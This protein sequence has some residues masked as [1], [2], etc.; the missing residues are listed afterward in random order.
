MVLL[1]TGAAAAADPP[2][3][4]D[5]MP[6][7][8]RAV[9]AIM[10][11]LDS[12]AILFEQDADRRSEPA[13]LTKVMTLYLIYEALAKGELTLESALPVSKKAWQMEGSRTFV[14]VGAEVQVEQLIRGIAVQSGND[15]CVVVAEHLGGSEAGF[16]D[17]MN[18]KAQE[19]G[20]N[21]THFMNA[22]GLP[23]DEHYTT[24]RDLFTL[25]RAITLHF[26]Q[27][28]HFVR[29]KEYTFNGILQHNRNR[30]LWRDS[31]ITGLKTGHTTSAGYCLIATSEKDGQRL[32]SVM[33]GAASVPI[34]S[35]DSLQMLRYGN[36]IFESV[37]LYDK[38]APVR[39]LRVWKGDVE[40]VDGVLESP[41]VVT[42]PRKERDKL[43]VGLRY[44]EPL[45]APLAK[46]APIGSVV[47]KL[48]GKEIETRPVVT[49]QAVGE[50]GFFREMVDS[51]RLKMGW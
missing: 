18:H 9:S 37:R 27:Y 50:G 23:G 46:G 22:S 30:L 34:R 33:L 26:P 2:A 49:A 31:S 25:T 21:A 10:G 4:D 32:G 29:E 51:V 35:D 48:G 7:K 45:L 11:D 17:M 13:S 6:F 8:V 44:E 19:L 38:G 43:E 39:T 47:V 20:M 5:K 3:T 36:R 12:G 24:A 14:K 28:G 1:W 40:Q 15:A 42:V 41:L 16:V